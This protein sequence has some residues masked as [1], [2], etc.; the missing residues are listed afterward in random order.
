MI[1]TPSGLEYHDLKK[2]AGQAAT[3]GDIV[4][5]HYTGWLTDGKQFDSSLD[6]EPF[7]FKLGVGDV[8]AGWD[9]G[10]AGMMVGSKRKL[11]IPPELGYGRTGS[12]PE[13][14]PNAELVFE[15]ELIELKK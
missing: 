12:L 3:R 7:S 1:T 9:E 11:W 8:I 10:V 5:V 15:V 14:P 2:G 4:V 13:I 6:G